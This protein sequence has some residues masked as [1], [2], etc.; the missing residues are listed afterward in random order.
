MR[1]GVLTS[2]GKDSLYAAYI[3]HSQGYELKYL[4]TII[5]RNPA[6]YM[7][8]NNIAELTELQT[9]AMGIPLIK[10]CTKGEKEKELEDL[11]EVISSVKEELDAIVSGAIA[12]EYQKQRIDIICEELGLHS[13]APLW[14]KDQAMLLEDL[15]RAGFE[16]I[17][18][19]V[20]AYG[21]DER[22]LGRR[23]DRKCIEELKIISKK[24]GIQL[25]G[26]GGEYET[27]TLNMPLFKYKLEVAKARK[28]WYGSSGA[29]IIEELKK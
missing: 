26:E 18:T 29:Y 4:I 27:F 1:V 5:P 6:S 14:H 16:I 10:K 21:L 25:A 2:G 13:F 8:H 17:I 23:M 28:D 15:I 24:H 12:S 9:N 22:W 7:F 19:A 11:K 3:M 20:A